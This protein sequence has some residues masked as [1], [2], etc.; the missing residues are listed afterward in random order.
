LP[1]RNGYQYGQF[2][3]DDETFFDELVT[4]EEMKY[5]TLQSRQQRGEVVNYRAPTR[6]AP[7][8]RAE[9]DPVETS[10]QPLERRPLEPIDYNARTAAFL[11]QVQELSSLQVCQETLPK[12]ENQCKTEDQYE[13]KPIEERLCI[14]K[15]EQDLSLEKLREEHLIRDRLENPH[16]PMVS[17]NSQMIATRQ[18]A[19]R[20][21]PNVF[22]RLRKMGHIK[23][24]ILP[25][26]PCNNIV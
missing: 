7:I 24:V 1:N 13:S 11:K 19:Y 20:E 23:E 26:R 5:G 2:A 8:E 15:R 22:E 4:I 14:K 6:Q 25:L 21:C 3:F 16:N 18:A 17:P 10:D 9:I 12:S